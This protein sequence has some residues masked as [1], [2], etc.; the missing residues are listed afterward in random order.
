MKFRKHFEQ[1]NKNPTVYQNLLSAAKH[2]T[3]I[4]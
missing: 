1:K 4:I 2:L 3:Y